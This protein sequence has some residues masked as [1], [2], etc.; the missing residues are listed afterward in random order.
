MITSKFPLPADGDG[1]FANIVNRIIRNAPN[2]KKFRLIGR[3]TVSNTA[4]DAKCF[5]MRRYVAAVQKVPLISTDRRPIEPSDSNRTE[6][7]L[8]IK[9]RPFLTDQHAR[10]QPRAWLRGKRGKSELKKGGY[11]MKTTMK[12]KRRSAALLSILCAGLRV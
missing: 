12:S 6:S 3:L 5:G 7:G 10:A 1:C 11:L 9:K 4:I 8:L 2:Q